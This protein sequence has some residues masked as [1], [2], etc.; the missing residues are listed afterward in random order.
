MLRRYS[1]HIGQQPA[2]G[3]KRL[4][5][6][7]RPCAEAALERARCEV[8]IRWRTVLS[9][10]QSPHPYLPA[11]RF[12]MEH[13]RR[14]A[15]RCDFTRLRRTVIRVKEKRVGLNLFQQNH[16]HI[17]KAVSIHRRKRNGVRIVHLARFR[18]AQPSAR[19]GERIITLEYPAAF[20]HRRALPIV[21]SGKCML[22]PLRHPEVV[23][24]ALEAGQNLA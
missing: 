6:P 24:P 15:R 7:R 21:S 12:P 4:G 20:T 1:C 2:T 17:G 18:F 16:S 11:Q 9:N 10:G 14:L 8:F 22:P 13:E 3:S 23:R 19:E 5:L